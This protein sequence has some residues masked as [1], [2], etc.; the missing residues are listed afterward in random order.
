V[1]G[2]SD[3]SVQDALKADF[4][5]AEALKLYRFALHPKVCLVFS[6]LMLDTN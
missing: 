3:F 2:S 6:D 4:D 5:T 1:L